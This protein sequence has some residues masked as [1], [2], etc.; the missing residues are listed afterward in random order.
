[1]LDALYKVNRDYSGDLGLGADLYSGVLGIGGDS[2][3]SNDTFRGI[4]PNR[5]IDEIV[6]PNDWLSGH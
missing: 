6:E 5:Y 4:V 1:M 3:T 2:T